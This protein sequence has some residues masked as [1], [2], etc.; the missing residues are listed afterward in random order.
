M[1]EHVGEGDV[2]VK[3]EDELKKQMNK[4]EP[5]EEHIGVSD[6]VVKYETV[7]LDLL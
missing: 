5:F 7:V 2:V 3:D 4:L 6:L 1:K